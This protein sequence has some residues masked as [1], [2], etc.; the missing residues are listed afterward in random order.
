MPIKKYRIDL[1]ER[2]REQLLQIISSGH[3]GARK[4]SRSH[5]LLKADEGHNDR[6]IAESLNSSIPTVERVR[7]RFV[8][9][10]LEAAL[11][12]R[13]RPGAAR[14][15]NGKE[16]AYLVALACSPA[17]QGHSRWTLRCL[18]DKVVE[19]E[20]T[21]SICH[22]TVRRILKKTISSRGKRSSGVCLR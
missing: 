14:K 5:I 17:P 1:Q 20:L 7:R 8:E 12:E 16:E 22:E 9:E 21:D 2:E 10:G 18:A 4:I 11:E 6:E 19:L 3:S 13:P 15:L